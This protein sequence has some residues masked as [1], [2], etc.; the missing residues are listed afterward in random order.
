MTLEENMSDYKYSIEKALAG[1][2]TG[3][4]VQELD[5]GDLKSVKQITSKLS[6]EDYVSL[7]DALDRDDESTISE[8]LDQYHAARPGMGESIIPISES[9]YVD[10]ELF[11]REGF[12]YFGVFEDEKIRGQITKY[13]DENEIEHLDDGTGHIQMKFRD[14]EQAYR[15]EASISRMIRRS[16]PKYVRD[17]V[18]NDEQELGEKR[19]PFPDPGA[20]YRNAGKKRGPDLGKNGNELA[21]RNQT[22]GQMR[23][24]E[25][26]IEEDLTLEGKPKE[27]KPYYVRTGGAPEKQ[28][29]AGAH[30]T[31][32]K[33]GVLA[34]QDPVKGKHKKRDWRDFEESEMNEKTRIEEGV[35]GMASVPALNRMRQLAGLPPLKEEE[36]D[37]A[38]PIPMDDSPLNNEP[39]DF[40]GSNDDLPGGDFD[41]PA[42][43]GDLEPEVSGDDF[44]DDGDLGGLDDAGPEPDLGPE[45]IGAPVPDGGDPRS[46]IESAVSSIT[47][48]AP[49]L[50]ISDYKDVLS[51]VENMVAQ[52]RA[53]GSQYLK[54][55]K[56]ETLLEWANKQSGFKK[57]HLS[58]LFEKWQGKQDIKKLDKWGGHSVADLKKRQRH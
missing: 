37:E 10:Y 1:H 48:Q 56:D 15:A 27:K 40:D 18:A 41:E 12:T 49:N 2:L 5:D 58:V 6:F 45:I 44:G 16:N 23:I 55:A 14:R 47:A 9:N 39:T 22:F 33:K 57:T 28:S 7:A 38:L 24:G 26:E 3:K 19:K 31:G 53:L 54:E 34:K 52:M 32:N 20:K 8:I 46:E 25:N 11:L 4:Q 50:K 30:D 29:G 13:L 42:I 21:K 17:S 36:L 43:G 35:M 51:Q